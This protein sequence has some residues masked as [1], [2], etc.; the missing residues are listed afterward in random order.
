MYSGTVASYRHGRTIRGH[1]HYVATNQPIWTTRSARRMTS[2]GATQLVSRTTPDRPTALGFS[3]SEICVLK[4]TA[5]F[6]SGF[7][8]S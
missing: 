5:A 8:N 6:L 3:L 7:I 4:R 2:A 1:Y